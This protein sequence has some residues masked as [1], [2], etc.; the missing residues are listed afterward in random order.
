MNILCTIKKNMNLE[1]PIEV[2]EKLFVYLYLNDCVS[3][4]ELSLKIGLPI[5]IVSAFKKELIKSNLAE[6]KGVF[7]LNS[8]GV[9]Y[10]KDELNYKQVNYNLYNKLSSSEEH[11]KFKVD[12]ANLLTPVYDSR[13][14]VNVLLDQAHAT[15][16]TSIRRVM[17]LL[18]NPIVFKQKILFLGD[19][20]LTSLAL[21]MA[22]KKLGHYGH[23]NIYVKDID[24]ELLKFIENVAK[25][26]NFTINTEYLNLKEPNKYVR[27][28]DVILTDPPYTFSGLKLFLSRAISFSKN[29]GSEILLSFG[30]KKPKENYEVQKLFS[31]QN[32]FIKNIHPQFNKYYGGSIIGNVSDLYTLST[33]KNTY[34]TISEHSDYSNKIYTGEINP[35]IK[36]YQ[37]KSCKN[38]LTIGYGKDL[39]TIEQLIETGCSQ[40]NGTKFQYQGQEKIHLPADTKQFGTHIIIEMKN[41]ES[42]KLKSISTIENMMMDISRQCNFNIINCYFHQSESYGISGAIIFAGSHF[43]IHTWPEYSYAAFD[44]LI[45]S[46][47]N[48]QDTLIRQLQNQLNSQEYECKILQRGF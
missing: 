46:D 33:T 8:V 38:R 23:E 32:L 14:R 20:D 42:D 12:L 45:Y 22:F 11:E 48:H 41:C 17:L 6:N 37:C 9:K 3:N 35:R 28:F 31:D 7:K 1:Q 13:P 27:S 34:P 24:K 19:D 36:F 25:E 47:F 29:D 15:L 21:M 43:S 40:C 16:D 10:V 30:Q 39:L 4:K 18:R 44:L 26:N 2:L 5:P